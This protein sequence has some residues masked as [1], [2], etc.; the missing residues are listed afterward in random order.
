ML[1]PCRDC[2]E[3]GKCD[4]QAEKSRLALFA[5]V[6][7]GLVECGLRRERSWHGVEGVAA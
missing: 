5:W 1:V 7:G 4:L 6:H 3:A 2:A